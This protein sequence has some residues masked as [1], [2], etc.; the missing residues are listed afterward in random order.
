MNKL[1]RS[2]MQN[3]SPPPPKGRP[4][5]TLAQTLPL[6]CLLPALMDAPTQHRS[7][8]LDMARVAAPPAGGWA[9]MLPASLL[10][11]AVEDAG[12]FFAAGGLAR[13]VA[14]CCPQL[15]TLHLGL[16]F[17]SGALDS[18]TAAVLAEMLRAMPGLRSLSL[19]DAWISADVL[20]ALGEMPRLGTLKI[21]NADASADGL[22]ALGARMAALHTLTV[23]NSLD[24]R[25]PALLRGMAAA[26]RLASLHLSICRINSH[27]SSACVRLTDALSAYR[28]ALGSP[29]SPL[30]DLK[31]TGDG[32]VCC[33]DELNALMAAAAKACPGLR[34]LSVH[35]L[36]ARPVATFTPLF[37]SL[38]A[39]TDLERLHMGDLL[40]PLVAAGPDTYDLLG[41]GRVDR[42]D[43]RMADLV[44]TVAAAAPRLGIVR[45]GRIGFDLVRMSGLGVVLTVVHRGEHHPLASLL[46]RTAAEAARVEALRTLQAG[47]A[48]WA[49]VSSGVMASQERRVA[50]AI[51]ATPERRVVVQT[52]TPRHLGRGLSLAEMLPASVLR[53]VADFLP[54][55]VPLL[56]A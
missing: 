51:A 41:A 22:E 52:P 7:L 28:P 5:H 9:V 6:A 11:L 2:L 25:L 16:G 23:H 1:G 49:V 50:A 37:A 32:L 40:G 47:G 17:L 38:A 48:A 24:D 13:A 53:G 20:R 44:A 12:R 10:D 29:R 56:I 54:H 3:K 42:E 34:T 43:A 8:T 18:E 14:R 55:A 19:G 4:T 26:P 31:L 27:R 33:P 39:F 30:R 21:R 36:R 46:R 15:E 35:G 45:T